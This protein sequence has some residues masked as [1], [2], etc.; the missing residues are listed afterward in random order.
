MGQ[1]KSTSESVF[2]PS[3]FP[4]P[5]EDISAFINENKELLEQISERD[6]KYKQL[7][8]SIYIQTKDRQTEIDVLQKQLNSLTTDLEI[9]ERQI[10]QYKNKSNKDETDEN[11]ALNYQ[12]QID[13]LQT[14]LES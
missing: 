11:T 10:V 12:Q 4:Q 9:K 3:V 5:S 1:V 7:Q 6:A 13:A 14:E 8:E 2:S